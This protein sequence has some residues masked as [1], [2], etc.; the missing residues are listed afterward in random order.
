MLYRLALI[1]GLAVASTPAL[2]RA[3]GVRGVVVDSA[4]LGLPEAEIIVGAA[5][6]RTRSDSLGAFRLPSSARGR[7][8]VRVRLIG[9]RPYEST[10]TIGAEGWTELRVALK[11][12]PQLLAEVRVTDSS[13][14]AP[15]TLAGFECRRQSGRGL[16]RDAGEIRSLRPDAWADMLDGMPGLRRD[17]MMTPD[18]LDWRPA[19]PPSG[20]LRWVYNGEDPMFDGHVRKVPENELV[21]RDVVAIEYYQRYAEVPDAYKRFAWPKEEPAPCSLIVYWLREAPARSRAP[22][23]VIIRPE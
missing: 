17:T 6:T 7:V 10:V 13:L 14:C 3:Q 18:G 20:C 5:E 9:Y 11:R 21:T 22:S 2:L 15:T 23:R 12:M 8:R 4:G 1:A 19:A 16:F